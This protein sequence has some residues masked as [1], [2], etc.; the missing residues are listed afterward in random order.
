MSVTEIAA[1]MGVTP[2]T[3]VQE[4]IAKETTWRTALVVFGVIAIVLAVIIL[5]LGVACGD[6][7]CVYPVTIFLA[8]GIT[9]LAST[10][11]FVKWQTVPGTMAQQYIVEHYGG[12]Q[13]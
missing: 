5:V 4:V 7:F 12:E 6:D 13:Q 9:L 1:Q 3:L 11:D 2:E 8:I 10:R